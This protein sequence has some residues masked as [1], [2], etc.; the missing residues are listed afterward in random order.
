VSVALEGRAGREAA[1]TAEGSGYFSGFVEGARAGD[2][3]RFLLDGERQGYPDPA[4][5]YQPEGPHGPSCVVDP[6]AYRWGDGAWGG[7]GATGQVLYEM[8]VGTF[9]PEGTLA[10]ATARLPVLAELGVTVLEVMPLADFAGRFGWG[11]D[12]V[13]L[14]APTRLYGTPDEVRR[15]VDGAHALGIGVILDVV[16]NHFGPDGN[17]LRQ[18]ADEYF[19][20]K[21]ETEW[22]EPINFEGPGAV[23]EFFVENAAY[24]VDEFHFDGLRLDATQSIFDRE[25]DHVIAAVGRAVREAARGRRTLLV[26][27]NEPQR[28]RLVRP[29]A[30]GGYGLD[31][32]WN[33]DF[34]HAARVALT[35]RNEAYYSD[36]RGTPQELLSALRWGYL[37]QGQRSRWQ[38]QARGRPAL[39]VPAHAFVSFL[40]NHDQ[41]AN[42]LRGERL[43][44]QTSPGRLRAM[45]AATLLGP[46]TPML[47]Q[48]Q[49]FAAPTPFLYFADFE[50]E[51]GRAV[52]GG[53][54]D[55]LA[56]FPS[57]AT[58]E[59]RAALPD[60]C[61]ES[62]F[63]ASKMDLELRRRGRHAAA[64]ALHKDLIALR[65]GD[66][67]FR[68][69]PRERVHGA[70]VGPEAF[71][72]RYVG[73]GG[74][75]DRLLVVN[76]GLELR[77]ETVAEPL[78]APP[79]G[80]GWRL[81]W[82]SEDPRY[83]GHGTPDVYDVARGFV[84][85]GQAAVVLAPGGPGGVAT[86]GAAPAT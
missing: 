13:N 29:A 30:R 79:E 32:L 37:M 23:R 39:D 31:A 63:L 34:H 85:P 80:A 46:M 65:R 47:F 42:G 75:D 51:L 3:Y 9:T 69:A 76:L 78:L 53:R 61:A 60:A 77:L 73:D 57:C 81:L 84:V 64:W 20:D 15:F 12:G 49:E 71:A 56:Q 48:G 62:T 50:G 41:V 18:F 16:Y 19:T 27:E 4:S 24:W 43:T 1:L 28:A 17:Y 33:D 21:Y 72:L 35:G 58:A 52:C 55:F 45:T 6:G 67:A 86:G 59:A 68:S 10:A 14:W 66:A 11:Y 22:G 82:S 44:E 54:A 40:Q 25:G 26:A 70:V 74:D 38:D 8:H 36:Y 83:G 7:A 5:R 2:R